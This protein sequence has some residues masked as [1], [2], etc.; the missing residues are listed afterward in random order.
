LASA[1]SFRTIGGR[2]RTRFSTLESPFI[3]AVDADPE[4]LDLDSSSKAGTRKN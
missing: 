2:G 4:L 1:V 3:E